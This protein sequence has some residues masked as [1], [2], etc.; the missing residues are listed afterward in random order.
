[1]EYFSSLSTANTIEAAIVGTGQ[2][3]IFEGMDASYLIDGLGIDGITW[4]TTG[5]EKRNV[6]FVRKQLLV[7]P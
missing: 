6:N 1:M 2:S 5:Q 3:S 7:K 4:W